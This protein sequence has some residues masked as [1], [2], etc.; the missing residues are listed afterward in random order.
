M[1]KKIL[2][3]S[4]I[5]FISFSQMILTVG[6]SKAELWSVKMCTTFACDVTIPKFGQA[7]HII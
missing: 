2:S 4:F 6:R 5:D 1:L 3:V 7:C